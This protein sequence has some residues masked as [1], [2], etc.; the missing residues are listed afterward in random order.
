MSV[1]MFVITN[2]NKRERY[3]HI[4]SKVIKRQQWMTDCVTKIVALK[5]FRLQQKVL[6]P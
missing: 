5:R 3:Y 4:C 2:K 1:P 6:R